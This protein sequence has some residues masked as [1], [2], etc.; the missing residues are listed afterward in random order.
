M[1]K[2]RNLEQPL[3]FLVGVIFLLLFVMLPSSS[4]A[5]T[6]S[7][8]SADWPMW[9]EPAKQINELPVM[10][11]ATFLSV[12]R[13][14]VPW[15]F[16]G[17]TEDSD[18]DGF[19]NLVG[20]NLYFTIETFDGTYDDSGNLI[21]KT[22]TGYVTSKPTINNSDTLFYVLPKKGL[23]SPFLSSVKSANL[24]EENLVN[25]DSSFEGLH[26]LSVIPE[27]N[28]A[29]IVSGDEFSVANESLC[30]DTS[31]DQY[32][33][34]KGWKSFLVEDL[35]IPDPIVTSSNFTFADSGHAPPHMVWPFDPWLYSY[36]QKTGYDATVLNDSLGAWKDRYVCLWPTNQGALQSF[37]VKQVD[38]ENAKN[39]HAERSWLAV[40]APAIKQSI[41]HVMRKAYESENEYE[42]FT[43][44]DGPVT[45]R[46]VEFGEG[47]WKRIAVGTTGVGT[48]QLLKPTDAWDR[49]EQIESGYAPD[50]ADISGDF[51]NAGN[52]RVFGVY[53][54]NITDLEETAT[55]DTLVP[56]WSVSNVFYETS[57]RNFHK[58][59]VANTNQ[60][61]TY[62]GDSA[63]SDTSYGPYANMKFSVSKPL[64]GYTL[65]DNGEREWHAI[66][67]GID[68]DNKYK[69]LDIDPQDGSIRDS[70][71]FYNPTTGA[72]KLTKIYDNKKLLFNEEELEILHPSRILAAFPPRDSEYSE[73][74]L[75][76]IYVYLSNGSIYSWDLNEPDSGTTTNPEHIITLT[77]NDD[78]PTSPLTDFD[79]CYVGTKGLKDLDTTYEVGDAILSANVSLTFQGGSDH[80]TEGL[81]IVNLTSL[82]GDIKLPPGQAGDVINTTNPDLMVMQ[83]QGMSGAYTTESKTVLASPV[84]VANKLY[85]AFYELDS[86]GKF[87]A[88]R[89]YVIDFLYH[90]TTD[91]QNDPVPEAETLAALEGEYEYY[92][93]P[94]G[95][96]AVMMF[97]DSQGNLV[98]VFEDDSGNITTETIST[99]LELFADYPDS[100][101]DPFESTGVHTV[102]WKTK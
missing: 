3:G 92:D 76:D 60:L 45:V 52:G 90:T 62:P 54:F 79:V 73:P 9:P 27:Y 97:I 32:V 59:Y 75:S 8:D 95:Q 71:Y 99:G 83:L 34:L 57:A 67:L 17:V 48:K 21:S 65:N 38:V 33:Y 72:E 53:A 56:Q 6:V 82:A 1:N 30:A 89:L 39:P 26:D 64:I 13:E 66:I 44:L 87:N 81:I 14:V 42:R 102:Y 35:E 93:F 4:V 88:S 23:S 19:L 43:V 78:Q 68:K 49:L 91:K 5:V 40:P 24:T 46:D 98:V 41:Y 25:G 85:L 16:F 7:V 100:G 58:Y 74:L 55:S 37:E 20:A 69:W 96:E 70:G 80:E 28:G 101:T 11:P 84:F 61:S 18:S 77:N 10:E 94:D 2:I 86:K 63:G 50:S 22:V 12:G 15:P 47:N 51:D 31:A 29:W 36:R